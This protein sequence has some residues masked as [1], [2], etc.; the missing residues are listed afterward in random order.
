MKKHYNEYIGCEPMLPTEIVD[1]LNIQQSPNQQP[2][3]DETM[4]K[5]D[6]LLDEHERAMQ[7]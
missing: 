3:N 2:S 4:L 1:F 5:M 7:A 6:C